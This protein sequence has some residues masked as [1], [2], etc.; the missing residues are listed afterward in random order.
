MTTPVLSG[1]RIC[2]YVT[3]S[4]TVSPVTAALPVLLR[5]GAVRFV[6][7]PL[8]KP[9]DA[10]VRSQGFERVVLALQLFGIDGGMDVSVAGA[11]EQRDT[12]MNVLPVEHLFVALVL[13]PGSRNEMMAC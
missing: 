8:R 1:I 3:A 11:T 9:F 2:P 13:V 7:D 12:V 5:D 6:F 10:R 4:A